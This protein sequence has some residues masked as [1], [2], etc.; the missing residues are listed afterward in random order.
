MHRIVLDFTISSG[1]I[2]IILFISVYPSHLLLINLQLFVVSNE[3]RSSLVMSH[4]EAGR[5]R[6]DDMKKSIYSI[7]SPV[8]VTRC[9]DVT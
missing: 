7:Q 1:F 2:K 5:L 8:S 4:C 9:V 6:Y 3:L